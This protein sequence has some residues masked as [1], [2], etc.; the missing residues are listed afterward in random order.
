[1]TDPAGASQP[2]TPDDSGTEASSSG[3]S[4][5]ARLS[6]FSVFRKRD[7]RLLWSAQLVSTIGTAL[8]DLAAGI[9][10]FR[11]TG[12][13]LS[14][15]LMFMATAVPTL[16]IGLFAGVFV[17]RYDRRRIMVIADVTR[18]AI[19]L[20]IPFLIHF[21]IVF[22]YVAVAAV[23][24][25]SQF[26][27]PA[28]DALLP[29]VA[30]DEEL[31]AANSW[32]M[33]S[34]FGS[35]SVGF[36]LSGLL[37][38][39]FSIEWAFWLDGLTFLVSAGLLLFVRVGKIEAEGD[40]SVKVVVDN[41]KEG[42][43]TLVG[44]PLLRSLFLS[45]VPVY[46]SFGLWNVLLLPFAIEAL[47]ATEFEYGLQEGMTSVGFVV[48]SLLMARFA[49]RFREGSW[50][51]VAT[52]AM[53]IAGVAYGFATS[54]P[55]A[56]LLVTVSGFFNAPSSIARRVLMQRNTPR[57]LRGRVFSA[58]AV[59]RDV[60]F[61]VGIAL[62][63]LA[64]VIDVRILVVVS[65]FVLIVAGLV[66]AVLPGLGRPAAEWRQ[67]MSALRRARQQPAGAIAM[68]PATLADFDRLAGHLPALSRLDAG[69]RDALLAAATIR[70]VPAG[71]T[72]VDQGEI[73]DAAFFILDGRAAAGTPDAEGRYRSLASMTEGD[74]F[75]EIAALT[76]SRRTATVVAEEP[77][78]VVEVPAATLRSLMVV[79][80]L[81]SL[82]L[83]KLTERLSRTNTADL[84]RFSG[85]DQASL[86]DLRTA[87][88]SSEALPKSY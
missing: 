39:A 81:G 30:T 80:E 9:L 75:G 40:T 52:V 19:V 5:D 13:A 61:L 45:G 25:V 2:V 87:R 41:L 65:S 4:R 72:I 59:A 27:N 28:N 76:G 51:V 21:N 46:F 55:V 8:T 24:T 35:T 18:A 31:A 29:E 66:T 83:S 85:V 11:E 50:I 71:T 34:S 82:F 22:L 43:S 77:T 68:R 17:D 56:I 53:G 7:F 48:G 37:A 79:P 64:D 70:D 32:I 23:S 15:G 49:E 47:H 12:S 26:F 67:A 69:M 86:K 38:V 3:P 33:I 88:P 57:E 60:V 84:P 58:F 10:V 54:I 44:T 1:M 36:A 74:F 63:G 16:A 20:S 42:V 78:T 73:G 62:A 6:A 14:V